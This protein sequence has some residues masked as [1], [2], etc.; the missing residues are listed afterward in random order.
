MFSLFDTEC[1]YILN[2]KMRELYEVAELGGTPCII[3]SPIVLCSRDTR[4]LTLKQ[5]I[6]FHGYDKEALR[7]TTGHKERSSTL[8]H[9]VTKNFVN[10]SGHLVLL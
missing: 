2:V 1:I 4:S 9:Y 6:K 3:I 10:Y 8:E 5:E 7:K